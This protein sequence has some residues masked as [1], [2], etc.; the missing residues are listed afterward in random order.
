M[1][2]GA[3]QLIDLQAIATIQRFLANDEGWDERASR[4]WTATR[5]HTFE[6]TCSEIIERSEWE[7]RI[8]AALL[9]DGTEFWRADAAAKI[10]G[11]DTFDIWFSQLEQDPTGNGWFRAWEQA[12]DF[13]AERLVTLARTHLPL[14]EIGSG[15]DS[16]IGLGHEWAAHAALDWTLQALRDHAG[17]GGDL[18][19]VGLN[20]PVVRNRNMSLNALNQWQ[21]DTWPTNAITLIEGVAA[22]DPNE[23]T[24]ALA[25]EVLP[26]AS[27]ES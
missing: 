27:R 10:R 12:D 14:D 24:R 13:R 11:I 16:A 2:D 23:R 26:N 15:P 1:R 18:V 20:S 17:V 6:T 22:S 25:A 7:D 9:T 8:R 5:R 19:L 4:G 21:R 3:D